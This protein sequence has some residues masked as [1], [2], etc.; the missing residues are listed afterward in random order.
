MQFLAKLIESSPAI[1]KAVTDRY[2][3]AALIVLVL[4]GLAFLLLKGA[5]QA[6]RL[7]ALGMTATSFILLVV[8]EFHPAP[9]QPQE[10]AD[11]ALDRL[12]NRIRYIEGAVPDWSLCATDHNGV[13]VQIFENGWLVYR[14]SGKIYAVWPDNKGDPIRGETKIT[15]IRWRQYDDV[16]TPPDDKHIPPCSDISKE[17]SELL[18]W[19]F[20]RL[21]CDQNSK[22]LRTS[23]GSPLGNEIPTWLQ[24]QETDEGILLAGLPSYEQS[25]DTGLFLAMS[26]VFMNR[27]WHDDGSGLGKTF[28]TNIDSVPG[29]ECT[30]IWRPA[31]PDGDPPLPI[32]T[33]CKKILEPGDYIQGA[34]RCLI[35]G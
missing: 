7:A 1:I 14:N 3:L 4:G 27:L 9:P 5:P 8:L 11:S 30:A 25:K 10:L 29:A 26:V 13:A 31:I 35:F 28:A 16:A 20:R 34:K 33:G 32:K 21:Y 22:D 17:D 24:F 23:L 15:G 18:K 2:G 12:Y 6:Y 19:G